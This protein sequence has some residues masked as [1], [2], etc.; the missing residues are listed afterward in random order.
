[1]RLVTYSFRGF[2][3]LGVVRGEAVIDLTRALE[4]WYAWRGETKAEA[5]A[6]WV[7]PPGDM[8]GF[9]AHGPWALEE[10]QEAVEEVRNRLSDGVLRAQGIVFEL[11]EVKLEAPVRRPGKIACLWVN[12]V[13]HG[14]EAAI[15]PPTKEPVFF[16]KFSDVVIGPGDPIQLPRVSQAVDYEAELAVVIGREGKHIPEESALE[17]VA[18]YTILND[19]SARDFNLK[20]LLGVVGPYIIQKTFDTF[21]PMGPYLV[22]RD[23]VPDPHALPIRLWINGELM[24]DGNSGE[25][26][27]KIPRIISYLSRV[28]TLRPGDVISTGTPP[29]VGHWRTPPRYLQPGETVRIEIGNLGVLENP[30]IREGEG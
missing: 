1:M 4:Q 2:H 7:A 23:E 20:T 22:T 18:G 25:M 8:V 21:A 13:E 16:A 9:L 30:V 28:V 11:S 29:G 6:Q 5:R 14:N 19:V 10:A 3:R 15:V 26:I 24:Q 17:Y 27:F 12:Y